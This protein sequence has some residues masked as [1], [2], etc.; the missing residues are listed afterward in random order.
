MSAAWFVDGAY[1]MKCW[2]SLKR[3]DKLDYMKLRQFIE[4]KFLDRTVNEKIE[5]AYYFNADPELPTAKQNAFSQ[6]A[7]IS[8][9]GGSGAPGQT[10]L[11]AGK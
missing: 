10:V 4:R 6:R 1:A 8:S 3:T 5:N 7:S 2:G 9:T 11:A